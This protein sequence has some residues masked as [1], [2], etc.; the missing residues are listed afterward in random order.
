MATSIPQTILVIDDHPSSVRALTR[1]LTRAGYRVEAAGNGQEALTRLRGRSYAVILSDLWMPECDGRTVYAWLQQH[2]PMLCTRVIFLT[3][4]S[5]EADTQAFL[6]RCGRP[7]L[8][9]P[10]TGAWGTRR[11]M[12]ARGRPCAAVM[13]QILLRRW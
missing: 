12:R 3:G 1:L 11:Q 6:A 5:E 10:C 2:A 7:W 13:S 4:P 9:K 8:P